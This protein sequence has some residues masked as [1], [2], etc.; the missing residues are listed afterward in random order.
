MTIDVHTHLGRDRMS[1]TEVS[2]AVLP[3]MAEMLVKRM[4]SQGIDKAV[5]FPLEPSVKTELCL[6]AAAMYP[7]K[8]MSACCVHPRPVD[9]AKG[10][11]ERY[12]REGAVALLMDERNY[13]PA[14]PAAHA[15]VQSA[16]KIGLPVFLHSYEVTNED[17]SFLDRVSMVHPDGQFVVCHMGGLF[18]FAKLLPFA[19]RANVWFDISVTLIR[20]VESPLRVFLD[21]LAQDQGVR[22]LVFGS[23]NQADYE[24]IRASLNMLDLN[25]ETTKTIM[26]ENARRLLRIH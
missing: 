8:L 1:M 3:A 17:I 22:H 16:V 6:E 5:V 9:E 2:P 25:I 18:G 14:D 15:L 13:Y 12:A 10:T 4:D 20:L 26:N 21:A 24:D 19:S 7:E 23:E 11:L